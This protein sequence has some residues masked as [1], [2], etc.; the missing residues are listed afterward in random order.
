M[1]NL[2]ISLKILGL[3]II[4]KIKDLKQNVCKHLFIMVPERRLKKLMSRSFREAAFDLIHRYT[5][6]HTTHT[7]TSQK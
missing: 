3:H 1:P 7:H 6:T 2:G 5:Y 4:W